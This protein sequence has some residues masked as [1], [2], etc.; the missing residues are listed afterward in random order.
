MIDQAYQARLPEGMVRC[1]L[2][3]GEVAGFGH[4]AVN[5]LYPAPSGAPPDQ[6]PPP[7]PRLYHPPDMPEFQGLKHTLEQVW[8]PAMQRLLDIDTDSLPILWDCDFL[9]G[10]KDAS[11]ED[12]YVLCE[13]NVS[14]VAPFPES[15]VPYVAQ[16][17]L[18]RLQALA[19]G[20]L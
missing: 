11:G 4:Q 13:I 10:P 6:A 2:V 7:G 12:T 17:T 14:S 18:S 19:A 8:V 5:A 1:Y 20:A 9:L 16:A 15:A 3:H